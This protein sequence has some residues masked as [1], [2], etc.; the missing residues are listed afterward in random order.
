MEQ[1]TR[2]HLEI[3]D[4]QTQLNITVDEPEPSVD[5]TIE[6][7]QGQR[8]CKKVRPELVPVLDEVKKW[9]KKCSE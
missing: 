7:E 1:I 4:L 2:M 5:Y 6:N 8:V 3:K 9:K